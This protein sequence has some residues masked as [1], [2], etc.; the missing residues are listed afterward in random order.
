MSDN[1]FIISWDVAIDGSE[2]FITEIVNGEIGG[3]VMFGPM[4]RDATGPF[5]DERKEFFED[6]VKRERERFVSFRQ[7]K[8]GGA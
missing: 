7:Q 8:L 5:M 2:A 6:L 4:P 3:S 1:Q